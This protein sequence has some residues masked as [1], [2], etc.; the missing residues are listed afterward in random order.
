MGIRIAVGD[1][2]RV[3]AHI[4]VIGGVFLETANDSRV[5]GN[6]QQCVGRENGVCEAVAAPH[7]VH[8]SL[9]D[10][11]RAVL[12]PIVSSIVR[13]DGCSHCCCTDKLDVGLGAW[14]DGKV[15]DIH[16]AAV[17]CCVDHAEGDEASCAA[18]AVQ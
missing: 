2:G 11:G 10:T 9:H 3:A 17:A 7:R 1:H 6:M 8:G 14:K 15:V 5:L 12:Q 13:I 4:K 18:I 16:R